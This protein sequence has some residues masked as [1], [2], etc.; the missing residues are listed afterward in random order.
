MLY[1]VTDIQKLPRVSVVGH[2]S[3]LAAYSGVS[4]LFGIWRKWRQSVS[5]K[6]RWWHWCFYQGHA[7]VSQWVSW[8]LQRLHQNVFPGNRKQLR[9]TPERKG[10][11]LYLLWQSP[12][13]VLQCQLTQRRVHCVGNKKGRI[14]SQEWNRIDIFSF[15]FVSCSSND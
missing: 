14:P 6:H 9:F 12:V 8:A 2:T 3:C 13:L 1:W 15:S 7:S 11:V 4:E 10:E 5:C